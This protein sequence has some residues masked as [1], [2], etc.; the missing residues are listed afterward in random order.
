MFARYIGEVGT[1]LTNGEIYYVTISEEL[2]QEDRRFCIAIG[3]FWAS[4]Y[5]SY[6][7]AMME[8]DFKV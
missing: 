6:G 4:D 1:G 7:D 8:W 3:D 5:S 2:V